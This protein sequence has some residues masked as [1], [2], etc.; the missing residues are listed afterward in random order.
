MLKAIL[1]TQQMIK[2]GGVS[3]EDYNLEKVNT[4]EDLQ[5]LEQSL[6]DPEIKMKIVCVCNLTLS[7]YSIIDDRLLLV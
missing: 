5:V 3:I 7:Y 4:K 6:L 1:E 2:A